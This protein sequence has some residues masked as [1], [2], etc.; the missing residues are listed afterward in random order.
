MPAFIVKLPTIARPPTVL[1]GEPGANVAVLPACKVT[2]PLIVPVPPNTPAFDTVV[3]I[4]A[5]EPFTS[6]VPANTSVIP[7]PVFIPER[8]NVPLVPLTI[9]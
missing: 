1:T 5:V 6:S 3:R 4:D 9:V 8:I 2:A 7:F